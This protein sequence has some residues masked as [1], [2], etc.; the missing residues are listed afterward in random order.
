MW[1]TVA[2]VSAAVAL[3]LAARLA[4]IHMRLGELARSAKQREIMLIE[5]RAKSGVETRMQAIQEAL[6]SLIDEKNGTRERERD[7][8]R[9]VETTLGSIRE[10]IL[11]IDEDS[12]VT[13]A[14]EAARSLMDAS[15]TDRQLV[16]RRVEG[17]V[18]SVAFLNYMKSVRLG[19]KPGNALVEIVKG[20]EHLWFEVTGAEIGGSSQKLC[21]F[22][23]HDITKLKSLE[24]MRTEFVANVSHEL[25][26]PVTVIRGFTD[27]LIEE[28]DALAP[29]DRARF[30]GKIQ[31]NVTRLNNL[32][33][34]L[35]L[36]SRL[37]G[38]APM[39]KFETLAMNEIVKEVCD[40]FKDRKSADC[41]LETDLDPSV[42]PAPLD[43]L[44]MTQ[45]LDNLLDNANRHARGMTKL[46]VRTRMQDG[47]ITC[48]VEDNGCGIPVADVPH[49]FERFYRV[50]KG[51]SRELGGTG[52]GLSIVKHIVMQHGGRVFVE[53]RV[54][55]GTKMGFTIP[56][57]TAS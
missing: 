18:P 10:A 54:G 57:H 39:L 15:A 51:R 16:G 22:A 31:R 40:N 17:L 8:F 46:V 36:L 7:Y 32:L 45:V 2:I 21:L 12:C 41:T 35:L 42:P 29:E 23:L 33:E 11:I 53:S 47:V 14:N 37:E 38:R 3:L 24:N 1:M 30:L 44:R 27:T 55:E 50:D 4:Y 19:T 26:T 28:G 48:M 52:L 5:R 49:I 13:M 43:H 34:D 56:V 9:Q 6:N 25:R 20:G